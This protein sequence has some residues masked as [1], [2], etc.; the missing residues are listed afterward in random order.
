M[1]NLDRIKQLATDI[2]TEAGGAVSAPP[3]GGVDPRSAGK[4]TWTRPDNSTVTVDL[5]LPGEGIMGYAART[6]SQTG[7]PAAAV[8]AF[9]GGI[10][11]TTPFGDGGDP[12]KWP[13]IVDYLANSSRYGVLTAEQINAINEANS[14]NQEALQPGQWDIRG[15]NTDDVLFYWTFA[16]ELNSYVGPRATVRRMLTW[17]DVGSTDTFPEI[18]GLEKKAQFFIR[19]IWDWHPY[20]GPLRAILAKH[21][22]LVDI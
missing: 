2:I 1:P 5:P 14:P 9:A 21:R 15:A 10:G 3:P 22:G 18:P 13:M 19:G 12:T 7:Y 4:L 17:L 8:G 16:G 11:S 6:S 20:Q